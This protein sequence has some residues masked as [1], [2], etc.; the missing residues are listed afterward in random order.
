MLYKGCF[1][2]YSLKAYDTYDTYDTDDTYD[3]IMILKILM[4]LMGVS[5]WYRSFDQSQP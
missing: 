4:I 2:A 3:I 1:K 5:N